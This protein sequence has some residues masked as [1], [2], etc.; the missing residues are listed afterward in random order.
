MKTWMK[1]VT[2]HALYHYIVWNLPLC[3]YCYHAFYFWCLHICNTVILMGLGVR[4]EPFDDSR[5]NTAST[6][7]SMASNDQEDETMS[8]GGIAMSSQTI[9][10]GVSEI[11]NL[12]RTL[13]EGC[14]LSYMY[15]CQVGILLFSWIMQVRWTYIGLSHCLLLLLGRSGGTGYVYETST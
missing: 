10:I 3:D 12:L 9:T 2:F 5:P 1:V 7:G 4:G 15:R 6:T 13:G 14:R 11:L 8:I